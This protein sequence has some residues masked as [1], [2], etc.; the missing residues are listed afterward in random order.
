MA[1]LVGITRQ[2]AVQAFQF[3]D[4]LTNLATPLN[5]P[6]MGCLAIAGV[7]FPKY[8]RWAIKYIVIEVLVAAVITMVLQSMGWTGL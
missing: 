5:G 4:G 7:N 6:L 2:V 1:D 8:F 3:G